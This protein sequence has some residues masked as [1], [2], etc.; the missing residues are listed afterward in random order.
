MLRLTLLLS[1][2]I[3]NVRLFASRASTQKRAPS[4]LRSWCCGSLSPRV[5]VGSV[6]ASSS[7]RRYGL[8][9]LLAQAACTEFEAR[10]WRPNMDIF[11]GWPNGYLCRRR[12]HE[13]TPLLS[14]R[15][16]LWMKLPK[17]HKTTYHSVMNG[18][19]LR[20]QMGDSYVIECVWLSRG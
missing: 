19:C 17:Y 12:H 1:H 2:P 14:N 20:V 15:L 13:A 7:S 8:N 18:I 5:V 4:R 11:C 6:K 16:E 3:A 9:C 10:N